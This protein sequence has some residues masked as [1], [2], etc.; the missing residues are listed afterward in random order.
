MGVVPAKELTMGARGRSRHSRTRVKRGASTLILTALLLVSSAAV[1]DAPVEDEA[2]V[3]FKEGAALV[4]QTEWSSAV[5]AFERSYA[6]RPHALTLYNIGVCQ[7]YL[8]RYT[9]AR[10]TI[11]KALERAQGTTE[12]APFFV[13][14]AKT[15]IAEI[16][17]KL[18]H[19]VVTVT[20]AT[21]RVAIDGRPLVRRDDQGEVYVAGLADAGEGQAIGRSTFEVLVDPRPTVLTFTLE[22]H[23][24]V[25]IHR[26]PKPGAREEV[27]VSMTEQPAQIKVSSN[28][29]RSVV[30]VDGVDVGLSPVAV[31][32]PPGARIVSVTNEG[33]TPYE[34]KLTLRPGQ[35]L[36]IDAKLTPEPTPLTKK[37]W[38]W[39]SVALGLT[40]VGVTTY[41]IVRPEPERPAPEAG[42]LGWLAEVK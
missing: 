22:G 19:L 42:G 40:A 7:R 17:G 36:P 10:T 8:G 41:F 9:L 11:A 26:A 25:E 2:R 37:W 27:P 23:D 38:F 35:T 18:A 20:P 28:V 21:T 31:M 34:S 14:Q 5:G 24:T 15:Y 39:T 6:A 1:A 29:P 30:R 32:R 16:D 4:E 13:E 12:L 33:Y 3:A